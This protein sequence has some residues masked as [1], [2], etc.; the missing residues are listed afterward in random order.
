MAETF[1][2]NS[3]SDA[4]YIDIQLDFNIQIV[5]DL[6]ASYDE[7]A[8]PMM[9]PSLH[10]VAVC[11]VPIRLP[12]QTHRFFTGKIP[13]LV[14]T[15]LIACHHLYPQSWKIL[16]NKNQQT[17]P[18]PR[19]HYT[20]YIYILY[21]YIYIILPLWL[22]HVDSTTT[23]KNPIVDGWSKQKHPGE[24]FRKRFRKTPFLRSARFISIS[25]FRPWLTAASPGRSMNKW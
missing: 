23:N 13:T 18:N 1:F 21:I 10:S 20:I 15:I 14:H 12:Q 9:N 4:T 22:I 2:A 25:W 16:G 8:K 3:Q 17:Q 24:P 6:L 7:I 5:V 11:C 19:S